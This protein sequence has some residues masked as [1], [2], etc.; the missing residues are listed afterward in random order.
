MRSAPVRKKKQK[1]KKEIFKLLSF[2]HEVKMQR[3]IPGFLS[4]QYIDL[5]ERNAR[6]KTKI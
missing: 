3:A 5:K 2:A 6:A 1:T 4:T